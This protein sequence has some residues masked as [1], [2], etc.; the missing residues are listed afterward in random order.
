M[1]QEALDKLREF[2]GPWCGVIRRT[3]APTSQSLMEMRPVYS[4]HIQPFWGSTV[5]INL[6]MKFM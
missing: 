3:K 6:H 4:M 2:E 1:K 5:T